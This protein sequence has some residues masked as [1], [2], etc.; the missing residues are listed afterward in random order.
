MSHVQGI[1]QIVRAVQVDGND[2]DANDPITGGPGPEIRTSATIANTNTSA[3]HR[4]G[5]IA[6]NQPPDARR[7]SSTAVV[8]LMSP[9]CLSVFLSSL[10]LTVVTPA[11]PSI[12]STF[13]A[14]EG[15]VWVGGAFVL[16]ST[17]ITPVW[18][19]VADIWGRKPIML[20][21]LVLFLGGS[22]LCALAPKLGALI[23]GRAI[24]GLGSSGM[25]AM[26]NTIIC[27]T[28]SMRDRGLYLAITSGVWAVG[29][30]VGPIIGGVLTSRLDWRW[31]FWINL[32][33][34]VLVFIVLLFY[35]NVPSPNTPVL[36]GLKA[37]DWSGSLL[38]VGSATMV[39]LGLEFGDVVFPWSSTTVICLIVFG[40]VVIGIFVANEWKI[41]MNPVIPLRLFSSR[42]T[43]AAY[44]VY[45]CTFYVLI[46]LSYYIPLYSQSVLGANALQSGVQLLPLIVSCSLA[47]AATGAFIQRTGVYLP[48]MYAAQVMLTLGVGLLIN[49]HYNESITK[50]V[51]FEIIIGVGVG[52]NIEPPLLAA[53][54][55]ATVLDTAAVIATMNF[56]RSISTAVAIVVGGVIFQNQMSAANA[57][58]VTRLG[59]Q[60]ASA[61]D[62]DQA[63]ANVELIS[64]LPP[65]QAIQVRQA[66]FGAFRGVWIMVRCPQ[67]ATFSNGDILLT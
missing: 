12:A 46:G 28:F 26:V 7:P 57:D 36:V 29:S 51:V 11:I 1:T 9:L 14:V 67:Y 48:V 19:S 35:L 50:M 43:V 2:G 37:I 58:L 17:A 30:A 52:M 45:A 27:D 61:F 54:A 21:S 60:L 40:V 8:L 56:T 64:S 20:T 25:S 15:Y 44:V 47:A 31:C 3:E 63:T 10:D 6:A 5:L 18:G 55:A 39:L 53:Q 42:S 23:A 41:A 62:G 65:A 13:H 38:I 33:I 24:Q 22:L 49:I 32:P 4:D 59:S 66:Y 34:G 16:A